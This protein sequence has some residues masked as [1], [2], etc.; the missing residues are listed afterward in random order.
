M[1]AL[2]WRET[3]SSPELTSS[4]AESLL[5]GKNPVRLGFWVSQPTKEIHSEIH[6]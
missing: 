2:P 4:Q 3:R 5:A 6:N 1:A